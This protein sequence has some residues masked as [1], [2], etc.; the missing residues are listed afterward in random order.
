MA[1]EALHPSFAYWPNTNAY[2]IVSEIFRSKLNNILLISIAPLRCYLLV[3]Y[4]YSKSLRKQLSSIRPHFR[5]ST[6]TH[7]QAKQ[8]RVVQLELRLALPLAPGLDL[9][10]L[11]RT[12]VKRWS[13]WEVM[14]VLIELSSYP[15]T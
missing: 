4:P 2:Y 14:V 3:Y 6:V 15:E 10:S 13:S 9:R 1:F 5:F 7:R 11:K 8:K 12:I